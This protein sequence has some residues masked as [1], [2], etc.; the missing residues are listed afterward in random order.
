MK[1]HNEENTAASQEELTAQSHS[2]L[3]GIIAAA[4]KKQLRQQKKQ[5]RLKKRQLLQRKQLRL[6]R[7]RLT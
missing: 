7:Q 5:L 2:I 3:E 4:Q 6:K 1:I